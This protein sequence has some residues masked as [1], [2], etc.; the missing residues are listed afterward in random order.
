M[1][2][3]L[4]FV[5]Y[6]VAM[7][8]ILR[9]YVAARRK[10]KAAKAN[11]GKSRWRRRIGLLLFFGPA[12]AWAL[13]FVTPQPLMP[14]VDAIRIFSRA[15]D[16]ILAGVLGVAGDQ[17]GSFWAVLLKPLASLVIYTA[18]GI[19]IGWPL[20]TIA[21]LRAKSDGPPDAEIPPSEAEPEGEPEAAKATPA[22]ESP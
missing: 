10:A 11:W 8:V 1:Q 6:V 2:T 16:R 12:I 20:D 13:S 9:L 21:A 4:T 3:F 15:L 17:L 18:A 14:L 7:I 5:V 19:A 22:Q